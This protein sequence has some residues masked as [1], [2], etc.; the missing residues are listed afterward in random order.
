MVNVNQRNHRDAEDADS[1]TAHNTIV[2]SNGIYMDRGPHPC[3]AASRNQSFTFN[4]YPESIELG[5]AF[6]DF[7]ESRNWKSFTLIYDTDDRLVQMRDLLRVSTTS[8]NTKVKMTIVKVPDEKSQKELVSDLSPGES[9]YQKLMK[10][11]SIFEHN[12]VLNVNPEIAIEILHEAKRV[13]R[14]SE[15]DNFLFA[16]MVRIFGKSF[17]AKA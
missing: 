5:E 2:H 7:I 6:K 17:Y 15:Y 1:F 9:L 14:I 3:P 11:I 4:Y 10:Q 16:S 13:G 8:M 12:Y